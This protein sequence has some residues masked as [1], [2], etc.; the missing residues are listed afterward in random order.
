M[1]G[2][3]QCRRGRRDL[4]KS[5]I[6]G[7]ESFAIGQSVPLLYGTHFLREDSGSLSATVS[8]NT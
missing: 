5:V 1:R 2:N 3:C 4:L 8:G 6:Q 7:Q